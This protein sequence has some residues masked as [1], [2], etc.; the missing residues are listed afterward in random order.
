MKKLCS[1]P[2]KLQLFP[3]KK[4]MSK[5]QAIHIISIG[6]NVMHSLAI[7]L[8]E[9]G[10][11]VTGSDD[12]I[13]EPSKSALKARGLLPKQAGWYPEYIHK[14]LDCVIVGMHAKKDNP[15]LE[16]ALQLSLPI[17]SYPS[18]L[19]DYCK[20]KQR[21]V[22]SGSHG[23]TTITSMIMH[24]LKAW[25]RPFDYV[26]GGKVPGFSST[27]R[28]S[29]APIIVIEGDEYPSSPLDLTPKFLK[30]KHHIGLI[31]GIALD[32]INF[33]ST[34]DSY[35]QIFEQFADLTPKAGTLIYNSTDN[36]ATLIGKKNRQDV[37]SV[38]YE[39]TKSIIRNGQTCLIHGKQ[40]IPL[41][42]F[43]AHNM[44][45]IEGACKVLKELS[46]A[47]T[48]FYH[49][50][51]TFQGAALRLMKIKENTHT[52]VYLDYA[53]APSKVEATTLALKEQFPTR[54]LTAILELH[55]FSSLDKHFIPHYA[56]TLENAD[57]A[58]VY[59]NPS[60]LQLRKGYTLTTKDIQ[61]AFKR[62][63]LHFLEKN[64]DILPL[65]LKDRQPHMNYL[66]MSSANFDGL[67]IEACAEALL[68]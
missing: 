17:H 31:S 68:S 11:E 41:Q 52:S 48:D 22:I 49:Y 24:V 5:K 58:I 25:G 7:A 36:L 34:L 54:T 50:I 3:G 65:L 8:Q 13:Y 61:S 10:I 38:E 23:K 40:D 47:K 2:K 27:I 20:H 19:A 45:N 42:V 12:K 64:S 51:S 66:F 30:Y 53:H 4:Y 9:M 15:E 32:H 60:V 67:A 59:I 6:G 46:L 33:Y 29:Q 14:D 28:L 16:R 43:G 26:V 1:L 37:K 21:I 57:T 39:S 55:T 56:Y 18:F 35:V 62:K 44:L 63:D